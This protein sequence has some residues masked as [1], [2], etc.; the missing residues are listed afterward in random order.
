MQ[1][2]T[3]ALDRG[4]FLNLAAV[5]EAGLLVLAFLVGWCVG[6]DPLQDVHLSFEGLAWGLAATLPLFALFILAMQLDWAPLRRVRK[7]LVELL[8]P[9]LVLC[10][11]YDLVLLAVLAGVCEELLFRGFLQPWS[12]GLAAQVRGLGDG[13]IAG[14][15]LTST[16]FGLAHWVTPTYGLTVVVMGV[17]LGL[18]PQCSDTPN[19]LIPMITHALYDYLAFLFVVRL[20]R[21][22]QS[23]RG[24]SDTLSAAVD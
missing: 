24:G 2:Q 6:I 20:V 23:Q 22:Q 4:T 19:V 21:Q 15:V 10:K 13:W 7:L 18:L 9:S 14:V 16:L 12:I 1:D 11:W 8:G 17:Y 3:D 5:V